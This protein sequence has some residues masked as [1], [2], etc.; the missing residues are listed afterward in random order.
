MRISRDFGSPLPSDPF[1]TDLLVASP[2]HACSD[3]HTKNYKDKVVLIERGGGCSFLEKSLQAQKAGALAVLIYNNE[4]SDAWIY[5]GEDG[6]DRADQVEIAPYN[7]YHSDATHLV[8]YIKDGSVPILL[9]L[10][11]TS[12]EVRNPPWRMWYDE[13]LID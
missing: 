8:E 4:D 3:L 5:M 6:T 12:Y 2:I 11:Q 1:V 9:P 7:I 13:N 10:N